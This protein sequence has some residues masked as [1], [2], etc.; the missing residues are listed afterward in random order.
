MHRFQPWRRSKPNKYSVAE[1]HQRT[2]QDDDYEQQQRMAS[3]KIDYESQRSKIRVQEDVDKQ[4]NA[5][6]LKLE[7]RAKQLDLVL[8]RL[9]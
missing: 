3:H 4:G 6:R 1:Q 2:I 8:C 9:V 5:D 7:H